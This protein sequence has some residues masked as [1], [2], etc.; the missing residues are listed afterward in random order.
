MY[1]NSLHFAELAE[2]KKG[3]LLENMSLERDKF[4]LITIHRDINTDDRNRLETIMT[5][6]RN[7]SE[8]YS[9][10]FLMPCHPRTM[11]SLIS[12][13]GC[14]FDELKKCHYLRIIPPV[15]Y[16][17]MTLLEKTCR[18][19]ITDSGGVQKESHFFRKPCIVLRKE[20]EWIELVANGTV[21]L[22]DANPEYIR[23]EFAG[24]MNL[25]SDLQYPGFYGDGKTAEFILKEVLLLFE[26]YF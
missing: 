8:E 14:F 4:I 17:E 5:S 20:T 22:A 15:S 3:N 7:L 10:P 16:L 21:K 24:Y 12:N 13:L 2:R 26:K 25:G 19:I 11:N 18:L 1:D 9:I 6:L 23:N